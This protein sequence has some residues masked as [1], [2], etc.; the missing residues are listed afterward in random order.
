MRRPF[1]PRTFWVLHKRVILIIQPRAWLDSRTHILIATS[2]TV[3][4]LS[5]EPKQRTQSSS[6]T[7]PGGQNDDL[8][9]C[10]SDPDLHAG[11]P[12]L[13]KLS[14]Q[15][16]VQLGFEDAVRDKLG[17]EITDIRKGCRRLTWARLPTCDK[18]PHAP[19]WQVW[20]SSD[21]T[22][23]FRRDPSVKFSKDSYLVWQE[24]DVWL[25]TRT[26]WSTQQLMQRS[27]AS[28]AVHATNPKFF[29][30]KP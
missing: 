14:G 25:R 5:N 4:R 10:R 13:G 28:G 29:S 1:S 11:V 2:P 18:L 19:F 9:P 26:R 17:D 16:L 24:N 6:Q 23:H 20:S 3:T 27:G 22:R 21:K 30:L 8:R 12:I 7:S 15:E